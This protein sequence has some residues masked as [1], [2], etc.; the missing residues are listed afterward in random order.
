MK[1]LYKLGFVAFL[2]LAFVP[3][4]LAAASG[5]NLTCQ[6]HFAAPLWLSGSGNL[7]G[8]SDHADC[9][10]YC[11]GGTPLMV[12]CPLGCTA[13]DINCPSTRGYVQCSGGAT[14]YCPHPCCL[15]GCDYCEDVNGTSCSPNG[16]ERFCTASNLEGDSCK[17]MAGQWSCPI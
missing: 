6:A 7:G 17:C 1:G 3:G 9:T 16:A 4:P 12:S 14:T 5:T 15:F 2:A 11:K 8:I 13:V 10:A